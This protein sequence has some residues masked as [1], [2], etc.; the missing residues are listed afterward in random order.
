MLLIVLAA[1]VTAGC[2][3]AGCVTA[4]AQQQKGEGED[5]GHA[6]P[7][8]D[9]ERPKSLLQSLDELDRAKVLS[10]LAGLIIL[11][12]GMLALVWLGARITR[13][14][15]DSATRYRPPRRTDADLD[16]WARKPLIEPDDDAPT[17]P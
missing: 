3:T 6:R 2:V 8:S 1:A 9:R 11:G 10:A 5:T 17:P 7:N 14:Y 12:L 15:M 13:R 16:D 4:A